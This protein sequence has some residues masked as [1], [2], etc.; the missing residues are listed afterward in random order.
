MAEQ[1]SGM[2]TFPPSQVVLKKV[3]SGGQTGADMG[4]LMAARH[5]KLET[6]GWAA[7][8]YITSRGPN[9]VFARKYGLKEIQL[10][11][12]EAK[13]SD[14]YVARSQQNVID[15]DAT[16]AFQVHSSPGTRK[17]I[18]F[19]A[20]GTWI[21]K[22]QVAWGKRNGV[23]FLRGKLKPVILISR[24]VDMDNVDRKMHYDADC[25]A[26]KQFLIQ[27]RVKT[28][29]VCGNREMN[30]PK[31]G[32][33]TPIQNA[34]YEFLVY[35]FSKILPEIKLTSSYH[36]CIIFCRNFSL[37]VPQNTM[38]EAVQERMLMSLWTNCFFGSSHALQPSARYTKE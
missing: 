1:A 21:S 18:H 7:R 32:T 33:N 24:S 27:F 17:T 26:L 9:P 12:A 5:A 4:A 20:N 10:E 8:K 13:R 11:G 29:N 35:C 3:V 15:S 22:E 28:L 25:E 14:G 31:E 37:V 38:A 19:C 34:V 23:P 30:S 16:L 6:G 36:C 2:A